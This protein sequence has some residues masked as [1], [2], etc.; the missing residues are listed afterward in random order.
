M[1]IRF[2]PAA[3]RELVDAKGWYSEHE[4]SLGDAFQR[5]FDLA[6]ATITET[7]ELYRL[8][9]EEKRRAPLRRFPYFLLYQ[10]VVDTVVVLGCIHFAR[11]PKGWRRRSDA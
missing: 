5:S 7:P 2:S 1:K 6:A 9:Y 4:E 3:G 10:V 11:D 8:I